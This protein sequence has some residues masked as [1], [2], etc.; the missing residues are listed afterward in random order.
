MRI[1]IKNKWRK[2]IR[3]LVFENYYNGI[4][5]LSPQGEEVLKKEPHLLRIDWKWSY[6]EAGICSILYSVMYHEAIVDIDIK[7]ILR[8]ETLKAVLK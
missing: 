7:H 4:P 1:E 8:E 6:C 5:L 2:E 3:K